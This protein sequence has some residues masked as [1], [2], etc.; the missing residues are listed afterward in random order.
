MNNQSPYMQ[1]YQ[2]GIKLAAHGFFGKFANEEL[3]DELIAQLETASEE[4]RPAILDQIEELETEART[5][6][7]APTAPAPAS[8]PGSTHRCISR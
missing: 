4:D 2:V 5:E 3:R 6:D 8:E 7:A 1:A